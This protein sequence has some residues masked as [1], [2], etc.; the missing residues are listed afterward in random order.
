[1]WLG[2]QR[3]AVTSSSAGDAANQASASSSPQDDD[4]PE[5]S[6]KL[7]G[8]VERGAAR[9]QAEETRAQAEP[10][11]ESRINVAAALLAADP[12]SDVAAMVLAATANPDADLLPETYAAFSV[13]LDRDPMA[14]IRWFGK[15]AKDHSGRDFGE[16]LT[17]HFNRTGFGQLAEMMQASGIGRDV[18]LHS[19]FAALDERASRDEVMQVASLLKS[20]AER[21]ALLS[22]VMSS[23]EQLAGSLSAIR[24]SFSDADAT[25]F[26]SKLWDDRGA[27]ALLDEVRAAGFPPDAVNRFEESARKAASLTG[28]GATR[29][30]DL[31]WSEADSGS[32]AEVELWQGRIGPEE[33]FERIKGAAAAGTTDAQLLQMVFDQM[34]HVD[35]Q[36]GVAWAQQTVPDWSSLFTAHVSTKSSPVLEPEIGILIAAQAWR[37]G[38]PEDGVTVMNLLNGHWNTATDDPEAWQDLIGKLPSGPLREFLE[39]QA[40]ETVR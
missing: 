10:T 9:E 21:I 5:L 14:A 31:L 29:D 35:P 24:A 20:P 26:L 27:L 12:N 13:W 7:R 16:E 37:D 11:E 33:F 36:A 3:Q 30:N 40:S 23:P 4:A 2:T 15:Y 6:A 22:N 34:M 38:L 19:V 32:D 28:P 18:V 1:M 17:R 8:Y 39:K 25:L